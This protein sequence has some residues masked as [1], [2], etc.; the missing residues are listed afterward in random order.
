ME[1]NNI[2][3]HWDVT[4]RCNMFDER[5]LTYGSRNSLDDK[6]QRGDDVY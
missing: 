4:L 2:K 6:I 1:I 3:C 5:S